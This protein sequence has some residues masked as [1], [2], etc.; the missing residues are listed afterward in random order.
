[1]F[2]LV[3]PD[4]DPRFPCR[5]R[6]GSTWIN[7]DSGWQEI[8]AGHWRKGYHR[9]GCDIRVTASGVTIDHSQPRPFPMWMTDTQVTNLPDSRHWQPVYADGQ[10]TID[11][12]GSTH[13]HVRS[14][15]LMRPLGPCSR[16]QALDHAISR[17]DQAVV[18]LSASYA[19]A[20]RLFVSG[21]VDTILLLA[22]LRCHDRPIELIR[23]EVWEHD[24]FVD[25]NADQ[26]ASYWAY[27]Q[28]HHWT[29]PTWLAT[30]SQGDEYLLRG[31]ITIAL[32]TS[33]HDIDFL[34]QLDGND[35]CYHRRYFGKPAN[36]DIFRDHWQRRHQLRELY[37]TRADLDRHILDMLAND[38]Q[39]WH[40]GHTLTWTPFLD[41]SLPNMWL[42]CDPVDLMDQWLDAGMT[43]DLIRHYDAS[44]LAGVSDFKN[45]NSRQNLYRIGIAP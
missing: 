1:M 35:R 6:Q 36:Q 24:R 19:G 42:A 25:D 40:L 26:L 5:A 29:E 8:T 14:L 12:Q 41:L 20:I 2:F 21:G 4:P 33:W 44:L 13:Y 22:L 38:H 27:R 34:A 28:L 15:D 31:P 30:G 9:N 17:L 3:G 10:V 16:Q 43:K 39:H 23:S 37:P 32:I 11:A 18:D 45:F 7:L